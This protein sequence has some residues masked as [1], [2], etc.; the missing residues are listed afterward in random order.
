MKT[1][2]A[3]YARVNLPEV[4]VRKIDDLSEEE[5]EKIARKFF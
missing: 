5:A 3:D 4:T 2:E 1:L